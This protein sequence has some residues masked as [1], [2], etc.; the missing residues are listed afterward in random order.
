MRLRLAILSG[1][2]TLTMAAGVGL[3]VPAGA[4]AT[5]DVYGASVASAAKAGSVIPDVS[6]FWTYESPNQSEA[7]GYSLYECNQG[8]DYSSPQYHIQVPVE[9]VKNVCS[10]RVYLQYANGTSDCVNPGESRNIVDQRF[11]HPD[12]VMIGNSEDQC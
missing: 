3:V 4:S 2:A 9:S 8:V 10:Y 6:S 11:Q 5:T 1:A 12:G 7:I